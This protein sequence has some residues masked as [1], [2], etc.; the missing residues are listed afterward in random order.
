MTIYLFI[1]KL[2]TKA[3]KLLHYNPLLIYEL[4]DNISLI[5]LVTF[6]TCLRVCHYLL[7]PYTLLH[8][9][10]FPISKLF[11]SCLMSSYIS[12]NTILFYKI[13]R[14]VRALSLVNSCVWMRVWK[15]SCDI[16]R[17]LI[18][19]VLSDA[20][21]DWLV[22][23]MSVYQE[24]VFQLKSKKAIVFLHLSNYLW[25]T[26]YKSNRGLFSLFP[27]IASSK[28]SGELG[29]F[30]TV[31]Q[32]L[33]C[34][35]GLHNCLEFSQLPLVLRW[36]YGNTENVL[37]CLNININEIPVELLRENML[38]SH[39]KITCYLLTWKD[40]RCYD[41]IINRAVVLR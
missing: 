6:V 21:F 7:Y 31:M 1:C 12:Y 18:G 20:R 5:T 34:V 26:V 29:E 8:H 28:H 24:S 40:H 11:V 39:K 41:Y 13:I 15:H 19:Y 30:S 22:G 27:S 9:I 23:N 32:T 37:Y 17:I 25:E 16:T 2:L 3:P 4:F 35:S 36:S 33:D 38:S 14:V 10:L